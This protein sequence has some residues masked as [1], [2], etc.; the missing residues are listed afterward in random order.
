ME[1]NYAAVVFDE[2]DDQLQLRQLPSDC[3]QVQSCFQAFAYKA[4]E[5]QT[6]LT[7]Y[8]DQPSTGCC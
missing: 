7:R 8:S 6:R 4:D 5:G 2:V 3:R 1:T